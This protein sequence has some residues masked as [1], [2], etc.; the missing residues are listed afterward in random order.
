MEKV[1]IFASCHNH[2][3]Y[4]DA[5]YTPE[6]LVA[7]AHRLGHGGI[8]LTDH[9]TVSGTYFI[10]KAARKEKVRKAIQ[11]SKRKN[12]KAAKTGGKTSRSSKKSK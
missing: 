9:D 8:I 10:N 4:S 7:I 11:E 5:D 1:K 2:S 3:C 6:E 12:R